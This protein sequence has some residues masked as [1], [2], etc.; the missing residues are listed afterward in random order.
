M[1]GDDHHTIA[2]HDWQSGDLLV[3]AKGHGSEVVTCGFNPH[4]C[5]TF[6]DDAS[7]LLSDAQY[8]LVSCGKKHLKFWTLGFDLD[9]EFNSTTAQI[10]A[11][12]DAH[13]PPL[14]AVRAKK[15]RRKEV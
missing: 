8:T 7:V 14:P 4:Q 12:G 5:R 10:G 15:K 11:M 13:A 3:D 9:P 2:I 6:D 1:G